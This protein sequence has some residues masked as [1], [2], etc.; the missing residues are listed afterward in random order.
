MRFSFIFKYI[1][2]L[3]K[4]K[5]NKTKQNKKIVSKINNLEMVKLIIIIIIRMINSKLLINKK[6]DIL[7]AEKF[8]YKI[9]FYNF[10]NFH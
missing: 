8:K 4:K 9:I 3:N 7:I 5:P 10:S 1:I 6:S 2:L